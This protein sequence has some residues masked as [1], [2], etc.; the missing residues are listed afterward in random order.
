MLC[1][2]YAGEPK[3]SVTDIILPPGRRH[4]RTPAVETDKA[5]R[6]AVCLESNRVVCVVAHYATVML[7]RRYL[8]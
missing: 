3:K 5:W 7:L 4:F 1:R 8:L 2:E 6:P